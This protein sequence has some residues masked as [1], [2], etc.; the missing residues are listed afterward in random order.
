MIKQELDIGAI[1]A[2]LWR[3]KLLIIAVTA[4][5]AIGSVA[6]ALSIPNKYQTKATLASAKSNNSSSLAALAGQFSGLANL[7]GINLGS[8]SNIF[9]LMEQIKSQDFVNHFVEKHDLLV[10]LFAAT[11]WDPATNELSYEGQKKYDVASGQWIRKVKLPKLAK[12]SADEIHDEF[13]ERFKV[14]RD[15][16]TKIVTVRFSFLSPQLAQQWLTLYI[17]EFNE[18]IRQ[19][20]LEKVDNNLTYLHEQVQKTEIAQI[21]NVLYNLIEEQE[22]K[23]MLSNAQAEYALKILSS[24]SLP[25]EKSSPRRA[26]IC[27]AATFFG[28]V[29]SVTLVL[30]MFFARTEKKNHSSVAQ[31]KQA[32]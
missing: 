12:P 17:S 21:E 25:S 8:G 6:Y 5:F 14:D 9:E 28:G 13:M 24:P 27:I 15:R 16:K 2:E 18:Y 20:D 3:Q 7:A 30:L 19:Q 22:K 31:L 11:D 10:P 1:W 32:A 4:I 29:L 23:K 26:V